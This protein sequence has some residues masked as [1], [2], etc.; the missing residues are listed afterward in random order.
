MERGRRWLPLL[1]GGGIVTVALIGA[2]AVGTA[3]T[4]TTTSTTLGASLTDEALSG[5]V[6][7]WQELATL[8]GTGYPFAFGRVGDQ[9]LAFA[10]EGDRYTPRPPELLGW[11]SPD[12]V[13]WTPLDLAALPDAYTTVDIDDG[14]VVAVAYDDEGG[15]TLWLSDDGDHWARQDVPA[16]ADVYL[17]GAHRHPGGLLVY[18]Q[19][20]DDWMDD[21]GDALPDE[22]ATGV[23]S[24]SLT[25]ADWGGSIVVSGPLE[26]TVFRATYAELGVDEPLFEGTESA[27]WSMGPDGDWDR[28]DL[29]D[30]LHLSTVLD[31]PWGG[32]VAMGWDGGSGGIL[33]SSMDGHVWEE[34]GRPLSAPDLVAVWGDRLIA[35][36]AAPGLRGSLDG[37]RWDPITPTRMLPSGLSWGIDRVAAGPLGLVAMATG[38]DPTNNGEMWNPPPIELEKDGYVIQANLSLG[39]V[40]IFDPAGIPV[41]H[42]FMGSGTPE[43][44]VVWDGAS[45]ALSFLDPMDGSVIVS[46]SADEWQAVVDEQP[47]YQ[48]PDVGSPETALIFTVDGERWSVTSPEWI[49]GSAYAGQPPVIVEADRVVAAAVDD[50]GTITIWQGTLP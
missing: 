2:G 10:F 17:E 43:E 41:L 50:A 1:V 47:P 4:T 19:I 40:T 42:A 7:E 46:V 8:P 13:S 11:R 6:L 49:E 32:L 36:S 12:L 28:I 29:E 48:P 25:M 16:G 45:Q 37:E 22:V 23:E 5:P 31:A 9:Y 27:V 30:G 34:A 21:V 44:G 33:L 20:Y 26:L 24:G 15:S 39:A 14:G 35:R 38:W 18:G 3:P